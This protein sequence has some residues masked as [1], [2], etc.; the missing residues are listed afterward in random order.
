METGRGGQ[1]PRD[2]EL[3]SGARRYIGRLKTVTEAGGGVTS[4]D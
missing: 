1:E 4:Q 3:P 2:P